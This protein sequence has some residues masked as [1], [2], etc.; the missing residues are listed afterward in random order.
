MS[1]DRF[2]SGVRFCR[3]RKITCSSNAL[4]A[5]SYPSTGFAKRTDLCKNF[6]QRY[7]SRMGWTDQTGNRQFFIGQWHQI[8]GGADIG[9]I[10]TEKVHVKHI[11]FGLVKR[12]LSAGDRVQQQRRDKNQIVFSTA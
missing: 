5:S 1:T 3:S 12:R 2:P 10:S 9:R 7:I 4:M 8:T 6:A 11:G